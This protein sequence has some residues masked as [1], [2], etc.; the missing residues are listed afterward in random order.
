MKPNPIVE[1]Q[2]LRCKKTPRKYWMGN[3]MN[4]E[5]KKDTNLRKKVNSKDSPFKKDVKRKGV[6]ESG[7]KVKTFGGNMEREN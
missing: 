4:Q 7:E 6:K 5:S 2:N 3:E 1:D